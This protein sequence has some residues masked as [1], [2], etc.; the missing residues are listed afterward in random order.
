MSLSVA[1]LPVSTTDMISNQESGIKALL[2]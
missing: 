1:F 2:I